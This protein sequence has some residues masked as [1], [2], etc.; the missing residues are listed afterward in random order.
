M[1]D[2]PSGLKIMPVISPLSHNGIPY[3]CLNKANQSLRELEDHKQKLIDKGRINDAAQVD[4]MIIAARAS[5]E[6]V[7]GFT[8]KAVESMKDAIYTATGEAIE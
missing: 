4:K 8:D 6:M 2:R 3:E 5:Y 1:L 7:S